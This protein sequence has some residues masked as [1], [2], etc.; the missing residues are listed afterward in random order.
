VETLHKLLYPERKQ[1]LRVFSDP[2]ALREDMFDKDAVKHFTADD[3][4]LKK[5]HPAY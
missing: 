2:E 1:S 4:L 3:F 5:H